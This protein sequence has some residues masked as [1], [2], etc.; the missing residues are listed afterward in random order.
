VLA[1][2]F[3]TVEQLPKSIIRLVPYYVLG[4]P[5]MCELQR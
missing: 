4:L 1:A 5:T 2:Y 3:T